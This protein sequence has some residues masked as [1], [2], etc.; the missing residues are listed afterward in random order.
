MLDPKIR[1]D[2]LERHF[3]NVVRGFRTRINMEFICSD[4]RKRNR[5][6]RELAEAGYVNVIDRVYHLTP[7]T[8]EELEEIPFDLIGKWDAFVGIPYATR[9]S[10]NDPEP[11]VFFEH[12]D[13]GEKKHVLENASD[14]KFY[15]AQR[16]HAG[17]LQE[18]DGPYTLDQLA[19]TYQ[20][21]YGQR[22]YG[23]SLLIT[24]DELEKH[25]EEFLRE[26]QVERMVS[27]NFA[28]GLIDAGILSS[29]ENHWDS[30]EKSNIVYSEGGSATV[31]GSRSYGDVGGNPDKWEESLDKNIELVTERIATLSRT[32]DTL[33]KAKAGIDKMGG[34]EEF[35]QRLHTRIVEETNKEPVESEE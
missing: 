3:D 5:V 6:A 1:K 35:R 33:K 21:K 14:Y 20:E 9:R 2:F 4:G 27:K 7:K 17:R 34:M 29:E 12:L 15:F 13:A 30:E 32:L 31:L 22:I 28:W 19:N 23:A 8:Y 26:K 10:L 11:Y 16:S 24:S 18:L 25:V